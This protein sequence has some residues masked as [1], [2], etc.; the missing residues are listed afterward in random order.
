[1]KKKVRGEK[2]CCDALLTVSNFEHLIPN[3]VI[4]FIS[5]LI[6]VYICIYILYIHIYILHI[7]Y[8]S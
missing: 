3:V 8:I 5:W 7:L 2:K 1:M 6:Y 4:F